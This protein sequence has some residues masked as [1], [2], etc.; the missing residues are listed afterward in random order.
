MGIP[1][2][3]YEPLTPPSS[4]T[5]DEKRLLQRITDIFD[6]IYMKWGRLDSN[7][8]APGA[9]KEKNIAPNAITDSKILS[10][11]AAK[12]NRLDAVSFEAVTARIQ[13]LAADLIT[14]NCFTSK[15]AEIASAAISHLRVKYSD[16][17]EAIIQNG[18]AGQ[19]YINRLAVTQANL[20]NAT[21][22]RLICRARTANTTLL[23]SA[24]TA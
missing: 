10:V 22:N 7:H 1:N 17:D 6:D 8:L 14:T 12:V 23:W 11:D 4:W 16:T 3:Q 18:T 21:I 15:W 19:L 20:L 9:V 5:A 24:R 2:Y 13:D